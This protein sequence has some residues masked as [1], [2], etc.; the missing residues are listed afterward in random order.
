MPVSEPRLP[1]VDEKDI[2]EKALEALRPYRNGEGDIYAIWA[3]LA[4]HPDALRRFLVFGNHVLG[5]NTLSVRWRELVIL[6]I[7]WLAQAEYEWLQHVVIAR[8]AGVSDDE[9]RALGRPGDPGFGGAERT[10]LAATDQLF[11]RADL[12]DVVWRELREHLTTEQLI[13]LV[14]TAG[15]YQTVAMAINVFRIQPEPDIAAL[16]EELPLPAPTVS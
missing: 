16:R 8:R 15:Q 7:A 3:T 13:D 11:E 6:R 5:K 9:I 12:D 10:L 4:A 1:P 2:P 14:Y